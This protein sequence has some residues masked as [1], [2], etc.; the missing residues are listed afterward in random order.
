MVVGLLSASHMDN[1]PLDCDVTKQ[2]SD[3]LGSNIVNEQLI[4]LRIQTRF[5]M[6][7]KP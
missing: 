2:L 3:L 5:I 6:L 4:L 1:P 7:K